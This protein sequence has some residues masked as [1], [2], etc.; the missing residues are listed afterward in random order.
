MYLLV[1]LAERRLFLLKTRLK[2][3]W[4]WCKV[5][6]HFKIQSLRSK[7]LWLF[8]TELNGFGEENF[9]HFNKLE[10]CE[11]NHDTGDCTK[12]EHV[13]AVSEK[14]NADVKGTKHLTPWRDK[15]KGPGPHRRQF[16]L[17]WGP[18]GH[19]LPCV[20]IRSPQWSSFCHFWSILG[21]KS[22]SKLWKS[23]LS[24]KRLTLWW[25]KSILVRFVF[26]EPIFINVKSE[27]LHEI[28]D[29]VNFDKDA[30]T[31]RDR[32]KKAKLKKQLNIVTVIR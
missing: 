26:S 31:G 1:V 8:L 10:K 2:N 25:A 13:V 3:L 14:S 24:W 18:D 7:K 19:D 6:F 9:E 27:S 20:P 21:W 32:E 11:N 23:A 17:F 5:A 4:F 16:L 15:P 28:I 12:D 30:K 29:K 22:K